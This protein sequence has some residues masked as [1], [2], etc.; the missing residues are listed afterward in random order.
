LRSNSGHFFGSFL[1]QSDIRVRLR[2]RATDDAELGRGKGDGGSG[3]KATAIAVNCFGHC[4][5]PAR[6][7]LSAAAMLDGEVAT[8]MATLMLPRV[9][10]DQ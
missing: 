9:A 4:F 2:I 5:S 7:A 10:L 3:K 1:R 6:A 8:S